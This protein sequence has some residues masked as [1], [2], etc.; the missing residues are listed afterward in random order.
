MRPI[1][2]WNVAVSSYTKFPQLSTKILYK[3]KAYGIRTVGSFLL[4]RLYDIILDI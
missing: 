3:S 1:A 4:D 2:R